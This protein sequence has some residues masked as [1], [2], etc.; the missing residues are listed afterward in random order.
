MEGGE[1][2]RMEAS[3]PELT[4]LDTLL[5]MIMIF[6]KMFTQKLHRVDC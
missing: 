6:V 5:I 2:R 3:P 4:F 1:R